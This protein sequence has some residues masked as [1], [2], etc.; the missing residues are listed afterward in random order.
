MLRLGAHIVSDTTINAR[1]FRAKYGIPAGTAA[2]VS[3]VRDNAVCESA[4]AGAE[5]AGSAHQTDALVTVRLGND[6][7]FYLVTQR[8]V[9][10]G[11][12]RIFFLTSGFVSLLEF[13]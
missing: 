6:S 2:D 13:R 12:D 11:P 10:G 8:T 7:P 9:L 3:V 1:N 4:T 5:A